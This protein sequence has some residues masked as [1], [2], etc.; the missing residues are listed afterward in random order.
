MRHRARLQLLLIM[1]SSPT[2]S[3]ALLGQDTVPVS[4]RSADP[5][6]II[7]PGSKPRAL[8]TTLAPEVV[9]LVIEPSRPSA[10][11]QPGAPCQPEAPNN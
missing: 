10:P 3:L 11:F 4:L 1:P 6:V 7:Q 2:V 9:E 8:A 5:S